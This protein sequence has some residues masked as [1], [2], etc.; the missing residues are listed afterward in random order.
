MSRR[1]RRPLAK[2]RTSGDRPKSAPPYRG[3]H[4][5]RS[6]VHRPGGKQIGKQTTGKQP[7]R[8]AASPPG[9]PQL[10]P[11]EPAKPAIEAPPRPTKVQTGAVTAD[12]NN[13]RVDRVLE[14]RF[15]GLSSSNIQ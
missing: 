15:P 2:S 14:A 7:A 9:K 10:V 11:A 5:E 1:V 8:L 6:H 12:E 13:T 3:S 4:A